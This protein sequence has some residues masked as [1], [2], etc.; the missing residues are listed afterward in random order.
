MNDRT[1]LRIHKVTEPLIPQM[2]TEHPL[3]LKHREG[4]GNKDSGHTAPVHVLAHG[5]S[6]AIREDSDVVSLLIKIKL[7]NE[8]TPCSQKA[9]VLLSKTMSI[10]LPNSYL[11]SIMFQTLGI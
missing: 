11:V 9:C 7:Q 10:Y 3:C 2:F 1:R 6:V 4:V 5:A 8:T